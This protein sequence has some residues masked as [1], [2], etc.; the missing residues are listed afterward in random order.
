[1]KRAFAPPLC[2]WYLRDYGDQDVI[3]LIAAAPSVA[4][5]WLVNPTPALSRVFQLLR[6]FLPERF[7][8]GYA[9]GGGWVEFG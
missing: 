7:R 2:P 4:A 9:F 6:S 1:V 5:G 3:I 8:V